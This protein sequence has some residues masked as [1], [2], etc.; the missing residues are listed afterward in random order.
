[1]DLWQKIIASLPGGSFRRR[2]F[3]ACFVI[4]L[5]LSCAVCLD[6]FGKESDSQ[7]PLALEFHNI[8]PAHDRCVPAALQGNS[9][10]LVQSARRGVRSYQQLSPV[11][12][13]RALLPSSLL[14]VMDFLHLQ[15]RS[16][17]LYGE[18]FSFQRYLQSS[19]PVRAGPFCS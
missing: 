19:L 12:R 8:Y 6:S 15:D 4:L 3:A 9:L 18:V 11:W 17:Q 16:M 14:A 13:L 10:P 2:V 5:G 7:A 1:M